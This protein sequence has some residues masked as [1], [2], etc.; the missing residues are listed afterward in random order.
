MQPVVLNTAQTVAL[1]RVGNLNDIRMK[2]V[3]SFLHKVGGVQ[4][5]HATK[6]LQDIDKQ[7]G[8]DRTREATFGS[9]LYEWSQ[10]KA[11]EREESSGRGSVLE[12]PA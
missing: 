11:R 4:L 12:L 7:V 1:A 2:K 9:L 6:D 8:L 5:K 3:R 10:T